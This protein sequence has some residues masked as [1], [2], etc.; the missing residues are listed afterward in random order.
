MKSRRVAAAGRLGEEMR[1]FKIVVERHED[2]YV[3]YPIG[4]DGVVVGQGDTVDQALEDVRSAIQFHL[5]TFGS[6]DD[7][8]PIEVVLADLSIPA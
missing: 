3:A 4:I 6:H 8:Q 1:T 2:G 5:E 7:E